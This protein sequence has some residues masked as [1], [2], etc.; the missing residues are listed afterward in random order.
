MRIASG[1]SCKRSCSD[2]DGDGAPDLNLYPYV[3]LDVAIDYS[4]DGGVTWTSGFAQSIETDETLYTNVSIESG[5]PGYVSFSVPGGASEVLVRI[6]YEAG[7]EYCQRATRL[8]NIVVRVSR[9][10]VGSLSLSPQY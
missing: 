1:S 2:W 6:G 10:T 3:H 8:D 5:T 9:F 7:I 4:L